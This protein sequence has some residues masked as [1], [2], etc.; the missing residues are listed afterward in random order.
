MSIDSEEQLRLLR[1]ART[2]KLKP[3]KKPI[4]KK[5]EKKLAQEAEERKLVSS[6]GDTLKEQWFKARRKEMTGVCQCGCAETSSK[7]DDVNFRSSIAHIFPKNKE[8]GFESIMYHPLNWVERRFWAKTSGD[9]NACHIIMDDT[10]MDRWVNMAD[11]WD[12]KEKFYILA[13]L[14]TD[15]ER[16]TNFYTRLEK[17]VYAN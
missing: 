4:R 9:F 13:P 11:W 17:L 15:E 2:P 16:G 3:G 1:Q 10:S 8:W 14:L 5:S 7:K 12:I 6:D